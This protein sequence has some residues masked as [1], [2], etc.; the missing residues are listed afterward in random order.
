M[1]IYIYIYIGISKC[2]LVSASARKAPRE[3]PVVSCSA[4]FAHF[5][6]SALPLENIIA[7]H[8]AVE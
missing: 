6:F 7:C 2:M 3:S 5:P 1:Y 4:I 8:N